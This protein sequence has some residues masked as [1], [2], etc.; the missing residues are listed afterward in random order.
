M[1]TV[2]SSSRLRVL[3]KRVRALA[4]GF[5]EPVLT[6]SLALRRIV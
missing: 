5:L 3:S 1:C 6:K 4:R 2:T